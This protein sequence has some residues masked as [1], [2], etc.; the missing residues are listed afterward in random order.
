MAIIRW[1]PYRDLVS[2]RQRMDKL[3]DDFFTERVK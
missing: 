3:F 2:L 1:D